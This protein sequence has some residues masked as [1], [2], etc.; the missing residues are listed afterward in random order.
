[1]SKILSNDGP[2]FSG[3]LH[4]HSPLTVFSSESP[5]FH[6]P[7]TIFKNGFHLS[8][9]KIKI[10]HTQFCFISPRVQLVSLIGDRVT[11]SRLLLCW[12]R[13]CRLG[14]SGCWSH[15]ASGRG[16]ACVWPADGNEAN[17]R[18]IVLIQLTWIQ[19]I[20]WHL[21]LQT[22]SAAHVSLISSEIKRSQV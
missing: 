18:L 9:L 6:V 21:S 3:Y 14:R 13:I 7:V 8:A 19:G 12:S 15:E 16:S 10:Y 5:T 20:T 2:M 17:V 1:M 4:T 11:C 22:S